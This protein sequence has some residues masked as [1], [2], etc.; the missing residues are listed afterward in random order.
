M[1]SPGKTGC[2]STAA[3]ILRG[4]VHVQP[5]M[6]DD[7]V[8]IRRVPTSGR[9]ILAAVMVVGLMAACGGN[10]QG[11]TPSPT[12]AAAS[13]P[14]FGGRTPVPR[15]V[16][17][18]IVPAAPLASTK[19]RDMNH[20]RQAHQVTLLN[21]GRVLVTGGADVI[22]PL[23]IAEVY[24]PASDTWSSVAAMNVSRSF[25][26]ATLLDDGRVLIAGGV[27]E[28]SSLDSSE[29]YDPAT[30]TWSF[31]G[32]LV[33]QRGSHTATLMKDGTVLA[34]GGIEEL[35]APTDSAEVYNP[36][37]GEWTPTGSLA[38]PRGTQ[39]ATL[40]EDGRVLVTG[41]SAGSLVG[42][43]RSAE[44]YDPA[45]RIWTPAGQMLLPTGRSTHTATL[46]PDGRVMVTGGNL[47]ETYAELYDPSDGTWEKTG[48][49]EVIRQGHSATSLPDGR[50][51]VAGGG[52]R[53]DSVEV[54]DPSTGAW[55]PAGKLDVGRV[56]HIGVRLVDD[57]VLIAGGIADDLVTDRVDIYDP[58]AGRWLSG[59]S[60][61]KW[62]RVARMSL[63]RSLH[64]ATLLN[65]GRLLV[66]GGRI[67]VVNPDG[68]T[69][70]P[71]TYLRASEIYDPDSGRWTPAGD[72]SERRA[73]HAAMLLPDGKVLVSG[74][75]AISTSGP[76]TERVRTVYLD[77]AEI[78]DPET[79][80]W[81]QIESMTEPRWGHSMTPLED[82]TVLVAGGDGGQRLDTA[83]IYDPSTGEWTQIASMGRVRGDHV[84]FR[85][86]D[87][88]VLLVG[89]AGNSTALYDP[90]TGEWSQGA[91]MSR[92]VGRGGATLL[93]GDWVL[94]GGGRLTSSDLAA[95]TYRVE[96][97]YDANADDW[98]MTDAMPE[99]LMTR[100]RHGP[101]VI[102]LRNGH[103]LVAGGN[104]STLALL[105]DPLEGVWSSAGKLA[106][107][108]SWHTG[109]L[110]PDGSVLIVGG[111]GRDF[112]TIATVEKYSP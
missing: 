77:S 53:V 37:T 105:Y 23:P 22:G 15:V 106:A 28:I 61:G 46:L 58:V 92:R 20:P 1:L 72:M 25:H 65:D 34:V 47:D 102:L 56:D 26:T 44:M 30:D 64:R 35:G 75:L 67:N 107:A 60:T 27:G 9:F 79:G 112:S 52:P 89:G 12:T 104:D 16:R 14:L 69:A 110:L 31:T 85:L 78:F 21:D 84:A 71:P 70:G 18:R 41:G 83:E 95:G 98:F 51:L 32:R 42:I 43:Y 73:D 88:R 108:R 82:G 68:G 5:P 2:G 17:P 40:L 50:V 109:T 4:G 96:L 66:T 87:G 6:A 19:K 97:L 10:G 13:A 24:N 90:S 101:S 91:V 11:P 3:A 100:N 36:S 74:G 45:T 7:M 39:T 63:P 81:T 8:Q 59:S 103:V 99:E 54:Y 48:S 80:A 29:I 62:T 86:E 94:L 111:D 93:P 76:D 57:R 38:S 49:M 33:V 55:S